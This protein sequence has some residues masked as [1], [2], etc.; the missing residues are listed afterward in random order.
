LNASLLTPEF[1]PARLPLDSIIQALHGRRAAASDC[2]LLDLTCIEAGERAENTR[3]KRSMTD[4][5]EE[6]PCA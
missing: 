2:D 3:L 5:H 4:E 6:Q 1:N